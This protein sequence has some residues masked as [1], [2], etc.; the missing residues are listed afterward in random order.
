MP[1]SRS[2]RSPPS[3]SLN[4]PFSVVTDGCSNQVLIPN[5]N[6]NVTLRFAPSDT[7]SFNDTLDIPSDDPDEP[8]VNI[9]VTGTGTASGVPDISVTTDVQFGDVIASSAFADR[10]VSVINVGSTDLI[11]GNVGVADPLAAPYAIATDTCSGQTIAPTASCAVIVRFSPDTLT[12]FNDSFDIPS[13][14]PDQPSVT[15][16]VHGTGIEAPVNPV[17]TPIPEGAK[18]GV[19]GSS[20]DPATL[21]VMALFGVAANRRARR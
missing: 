1:I 13:N 5:A 9:D 7:G 11:F 18:P 4:P 3:I 17:T 20:A 10:T 8:S 2:G 15:V 16:M 21:L 12:A 14:D 19:F 6:C